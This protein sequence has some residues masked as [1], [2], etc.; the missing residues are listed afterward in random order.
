MPDKLGPATVS[1]PRR[2]QL[3][4]TVSPLLSHLHY[5]V[6]KTI[7]HSYLSAICYHGRFLFFRKSSQRTGRREEGLALAAEKQFR[8]GG[9]PLPLP[10]PPVPPVKRKEAAMEEVMGMTLVP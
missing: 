4:S 9:F 6:I 7:Y 8:G 1:G 10:R 3:A 2:Q 5:A